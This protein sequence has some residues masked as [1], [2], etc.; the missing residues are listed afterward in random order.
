MIIIA[1]VLFPD[2]FCLSNFMWIHILDVLFAKWCTLFPSAHISQYMSL[3]SVTEY[4]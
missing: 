4:Y 2:M 1:G 3:I